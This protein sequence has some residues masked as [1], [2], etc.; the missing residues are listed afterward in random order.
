VLLAESAADALAIVREPHV[1]DVLLTDVVLGAGLNGVDVA[2]Q[3]R[4]RRPTLPVLFISGYTAVPEAQ[5]RITAL[6]AALLFKPVTLSQLANAIAA[7]QDIKS[8]SRI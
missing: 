1:L 4:A 3:A 2:E 8:E 5:G 7:A 6:G